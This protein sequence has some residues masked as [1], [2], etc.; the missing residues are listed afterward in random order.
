MKENIIK[1]YTSKYL[2]FK[3]FPKEQSYSIRDIFIDHWSDFCEYANDNNLNIRDI[4][5]FE[6]A[7]MMKCKTP[8]LGFSLYECSKCHNTHIQF[9]PANLNFALHV[10]INI[11]TIELFLLNL[12][13]TIAIIVTLFLL[14]MMLYGIFSEK[15]EID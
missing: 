9:I 13:Y 8:Q 11:L 12:N 10:E 1:T 4:V 6:V 15:I 2:M 5:Y 3:D 14:F 7:K